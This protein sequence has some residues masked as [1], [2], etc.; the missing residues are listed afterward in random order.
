MPSGNELGANEQWIPEA[1]IDSPLP[2]EFVSS[3][4]FR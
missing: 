3:S 1:V 4:I 2:D